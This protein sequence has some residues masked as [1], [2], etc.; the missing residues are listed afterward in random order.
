[1]DLGAGKMAWKLREHSTLI[2]D[3]NSQPPLNPV[4]GHLIPLA[5][6]D[7]GTLVGVLPPS[8]NVTRK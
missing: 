3:L 1:M 5:S 6:T 8:I 2:E 7:T 4:P